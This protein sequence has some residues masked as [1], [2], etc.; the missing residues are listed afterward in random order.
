M[1]KFYV[2][3][4]F[5]KLEELKTSCQMTDKSLSNSIM[6]QNYS[7]IKPQNIKDDQDDEH[8]KDL[9]LS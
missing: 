4:R 1:K 2:Y 6:D 8:H 3:N 7:L 9:A 5:G